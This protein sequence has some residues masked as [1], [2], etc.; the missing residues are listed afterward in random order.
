LISQHSIVLAVLG[1]SED[2]RHDLTSYERETI[3]ALAT[4]LHRRSGWEV[5]PCPFRLA[6]LEGVLLYELAPGDDVI[7]RSTCAYFSRDP[8]VQANGLLAAHALAG[9]MLLRR[10]LDLGPVHAWMLAAEL[11]TPMWAIDVIDDHPNAPPWLVR[12]RR[13]A[14]SPSP[15]NALAG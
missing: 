15:T 1:L 7:F 13:R 2:G 5:P 9:A 4:D 8:S 14:S 3:V 12:L 11:L 10:D 6:A